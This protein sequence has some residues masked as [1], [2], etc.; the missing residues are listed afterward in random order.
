MACG[1]LMSW[2]L[3]W[4]YDIPMVEL[5]ITVFMVRQWHGDAISP[6]GDDCPA[7]CMQ[8][9]MCFF[10]AEIF[11]FSGGGFVHCDQRCPAQP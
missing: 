9:Y 5:S 3:D 2:W 11:K 1:I 8:A 6:P 7:S 10:I 4:A